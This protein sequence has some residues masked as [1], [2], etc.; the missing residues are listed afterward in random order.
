MNVD[1]SQTIEKEETVFIFGS[2]IWGM[3]IGGTLGIIESLISIRLWIAFGSPSFL[4]K[5][6]IEGDSI[7]LA[8]AFIS[9]GILIG[10]LFGVIVGIIAL[11]LQIIVRF[12][13]LYLSLILLGVIVYALM[14][15]VDLKFQ[16]FPFSLVC[17]PFL[18]IAGLRLAG[19][20]RVK[21]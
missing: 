12:F 14:Y 11:K 21:N 19:V 6:H 1:E 20:L 2:I 15:T 7:I 10:A 4:I 9:G 17:D 13:R 3:L 16:I 5:P 8:T 18:F